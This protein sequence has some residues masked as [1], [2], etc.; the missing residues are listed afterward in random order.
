MGAAKEREAG[1]RQ[2]GE[3]GSVMTERSR[4]QSINEIR[5]EKKKKKKKKKKTGR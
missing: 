1:T 3:G 4:S 5:K 2:E